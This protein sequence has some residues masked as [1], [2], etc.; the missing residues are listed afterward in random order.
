MPAGELDKL[1]TLVRRAH[2]AGYRLRFWATP[3]APGL[4]RAALWSVLADN[5]VDHLNTDDLVG[6]SRFL[7]TRGPA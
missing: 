5:G 2:G 7:L 6:L 3:D 1:Q 4:E